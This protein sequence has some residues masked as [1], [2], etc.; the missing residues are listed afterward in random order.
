MWQIIFCYVAWDKPK[1]DGLPE[2]YKKCQKWKLPKP[3]NFWR[4][5]AKRIA[6]SNPAYFSPPRLCGVVRFLLFSG[7]F[8]LLL[9]P[10]PLPPLLCKAPPAIYRQ[11]PP[12][13]SP[14]RAPTSIASSLKLSSYI[15]PAASWTLPFPGPYFYSFLCKGLQLYTAS[16][17]LGPPLSG[18]LLL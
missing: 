15:P 17:L 9:L 7:S 3:Y 1:A 18:P 10:P 14:F 11:L 2:K 16:C 4:F 13:P 8:L 5:Q 12:G 6:D